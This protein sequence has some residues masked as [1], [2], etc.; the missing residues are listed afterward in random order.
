M[1]IKGYMITTQAMQQ[2]GEERF[3]ETKHPSGRTIYWN[4][5]KEGAHRPRGH[6]HLGGNEGYVSVTPMKLG[7]TDPSQMDALRAI[8]K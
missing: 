5:F 7:E 4:V 3:A 6:G 8:F 2:S 1:A